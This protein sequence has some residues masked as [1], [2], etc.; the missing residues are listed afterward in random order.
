MYEF[1][2]GK[3]ATV[4]ANYVVIEAQ[5][6]GYRLSIP[7]SYVGKFGELG[8]EQI[9]YSSFIIREFSQTLYGFF[10]CQE[11]ELFEI[12]VAI[13]GIGPKTALSLVGH[14][15]QD[16]L[17]QAVQNQDSAAFVKVPGIGAKTAERLVIELKGK[18]KFILPTVS[19]RSGKSLIMHDALA[20]LMNLGYNQARAEKAVQ[21]AQEL[22]SDEADL[23]EVIALAL[24]N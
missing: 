24:R 10:T 13:S 2:R 19:V 16:A 11:R 23:S 14:L 15:P 6:V 18:L 22:L 7:I 1:I 4:A 21:K 12:L 17:V 9:L 20:A 5:G 8:S 3:L